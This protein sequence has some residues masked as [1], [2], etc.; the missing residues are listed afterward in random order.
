MEGFIFG[1]GRK[2]PGTGSRRRLWGGGDG[3]GDKTGALSS[4]ILWDV[5]LCF[6]LFW[7]V[8]VWFLP[9]FL[10]R[11]WC[12]CGDKVTRRKSVPWRWFTRAEEAG[13][14]WGCDGVGGGAGRIASRARSVG[15]FSVMVPKNQEQGVSLSFFLFYFCFI[16]YFFARA[17]GKVVGVGW[18]LWY[19]RG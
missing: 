12:H 7:L 15:L 19:C 13:R 8:L 11:R 10:V 2:L 9:L 6:V 14:R 18:P 1:R 16:F 17:L 3:G 5:L 4:G